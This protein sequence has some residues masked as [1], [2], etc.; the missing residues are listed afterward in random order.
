MR[1]FNSANELTIEKIL[2]MFNQF[3]CNPSNYSFYFCGKF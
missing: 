1:Y 3:S 2:T